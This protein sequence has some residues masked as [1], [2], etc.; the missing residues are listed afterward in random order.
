MLRSR[1]IIE[2]MSFLFHQR[3]EREKRCGIVEHLDAHTS[4]FSADV[5]DANELIPWIR[6][7]I[8]RITDIQFSNKTLEEQ[9]KNDLG[10]MYE[11]YGLNDQNEQKGGE[12]HAI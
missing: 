1:F 10:Q 9:F 4:R 5:Y 11:L 8:C 3:L 7:F 2:V 12:K 6:T